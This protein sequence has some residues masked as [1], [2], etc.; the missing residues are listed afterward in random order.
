MRGLPKGRLLRAMGRHPRPPEIS[1][2][3]VDATLVIFY[4]LP[5]N[6]KFLGSYCWILSNSHR[7]GRAMRCQGFFCT[8]AYRRNEIYSPWLSIIGGATSLQDPEAK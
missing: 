8:A 6:R 7:P 1:S 4:N 3:P 2:S 5:N